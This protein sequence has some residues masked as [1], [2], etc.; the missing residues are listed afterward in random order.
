M[1]E[2][3]SAEALDQLFRRARSHDGDPASIF[4]RVPR[5][6]FEEFTTIV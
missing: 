1:A 5:P 2:P 4:E 3:L 6:S